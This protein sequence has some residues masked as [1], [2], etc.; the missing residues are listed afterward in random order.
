[1][2]VMADIEHP[3]DS[4]PLTVQDLEGMPDDGRRHELIDGVLVVSPAPGL[5]HQKI[6]YGLYGVLEAA[7]PPDCEVVGAPFAV[8]SGDRIELQPD[9]L[10]GRG[11]D[12]TELDLPAPPLLAVE[13]L[14]PSTAIHDLNTKK[15]VYERLGT[16]SYW[17][18]DP[19][20]PAL[21]VFELDADGCYHQAAKAAGD[22]VIELER[23]FRV[24]I[25]P[26]DL[27]GR[28]G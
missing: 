26:R 11:E 17:V 24:R 5:R 22:E 9:V 7:C 3:A 28:L 20:E 2:T 18:I 1:M 21:T 16:A 6:A 4:G 10:V 23:P 12:F 27:L 19:Q 8:H 15:A 25:V 14:S 13:V